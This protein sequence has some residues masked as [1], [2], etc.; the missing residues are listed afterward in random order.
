MK[1]L[2]CPGR[3]AGRP[4][5]FLSETEML[6][7][8]NF[9]ILVFIFICSSS[10]QA[11]GD[12]DNRPLQRE[13]FAYGMDLTI[14]GNHAIYGLTLPAAIYQGCTTSDLGDLRVFNADHPVPHL[15]RSQVSKETKRPAQ[16]LPFF[17]L[18]SDTQGGSGSPPDLH[19]ATT[20]T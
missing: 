16:A 10:V 4:Y 8:R 13:D 18:L 2:R 6:F 1:L 19:I 15:L 17:P 7:L 20:Q 5:G 12:D 9:L 14:S 3:L 11:S